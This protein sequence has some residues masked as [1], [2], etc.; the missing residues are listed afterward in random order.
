MH[1][2]LLHRDEDILLQSIV[3]NAVGS[4]RAVSAKIYDKAIIF[5]TDITDTISVISDLRYLP[6]LM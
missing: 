6:R 3:S 1:Y 2:T 4:H 5:Q